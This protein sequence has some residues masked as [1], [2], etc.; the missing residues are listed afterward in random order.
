M[1]EEVQA[2]KDELA[3]VRAREKRFK[4][5]AEAK[6]T[7]LQEELVNFKTKMLEAEA[8]VTDIEAQ[9]QASKARCQNLEEMSAKFQQEKAVLQ[10]QLDA[11]KEA[12]A[13]ARKD[14]TELAWATRRQQEL[15]QENIQL[16]NQLEELEC[17]QLALD[18]ELTQHKE[19]LKKY[20]PLETF[21]KNAPFHPLVLHL[22]R[23]FSAGKR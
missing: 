18:A 15:E 14:Q 21:M 12:E 5:E 9:L 23:L 22:N 19:L 7:H 20:L 13:Q 1:E 4:D 10:G 17:S 2:L 8:R 16:K 11:S 6:I 3:R